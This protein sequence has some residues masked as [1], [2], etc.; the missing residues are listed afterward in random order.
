MPAPFLLT[1]SC[2]DQIREQFLTCRFQLTISRSTL[3]DSTASK[4]LQLGKISV[5]SVQ[6]STGP[7]T[8][9]CHT[10]V[11]DI[12]LNEQYQFVLTVRLQVIQWGGG[13][14]S[15]AR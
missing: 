11:I 5:P 8:L 1:A 4:D 9:R 13:W 10:N 15:I 6:C 2:C 3:A 7:Y 14:A 12:L